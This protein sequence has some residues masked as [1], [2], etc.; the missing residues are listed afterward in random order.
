V[1]RE[2]VVGLINGLTVAICVGAGAGLWFESADIGI[3]I[4][5]ALVVT[6]LVAGMIGA[7]VPLILDRLKSDPAVASGVI[8]TAITD[9]TGFFVFLGLAGWWFGLV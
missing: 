3:V 2:V 4:G 6:I 8:L 1:G 5:V 9:I 7:L